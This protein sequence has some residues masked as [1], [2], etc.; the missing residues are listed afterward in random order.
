MGL[1]SSAY[2]AAHGVLADQ[3]LEYFN[4]EALPTATLAVKGRK[5]VNSRGQAVP[6]SDNVI[7]NGSRIAVAD[8]Q[9]MIIVEQGRILDVSTEPGEYIFDIGTEPSLL[10]GGTFTEGARAALEKT[11]ERFKFGGQPGKDTRVYYFN[12]KELLANPYGTANPVP[13]RVVDA[14]IG[15]D[16]D[17]AI[18][19]F[20]QYSYRI[21][22]PI[23]F[24][25]N[26][27]GNFPVAYTRDLIDGQLKAELLGALQPAVA[28]ISAAGVRYSALPGHTAEL[29]EALNAVLSPT[30]RETRGL[31]IVACG[32]SSVSA[33]PEDEQ[34]IKDLQ[35]TAV[36]R[37][38]TMAAATLI[39]AQASALEAAASNESGAMLGL[40]GLGMAHTAGGR[41][42]T[43]SLYALGRKSTPPHD[44][45][46]PGAEPPSAGWSCTS[47]GTTNE[48]R[49]C[50]ECGASK[51]PGVPQYRCDKCGWTPP[52]PGNPPKFCPDCGDP[53]DDGDLA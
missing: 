43:S 44:P 21:C 19:F 8:G 4:C 17:I 32:V 31:E 9:C 20:G 15:L 14:N 30:W 16:M 51:P 48:G 36:L 6:G 27:A 33:S 23:L 12:T 24:Y 29:A 2:A 47:C 10:G 46:P 25:M 39:G 35:R 28:R 22:D 18:R 3:W 26:V 13:F 45:T 7:S 50:H 37:D 5:W 34:M 53:F 49:F 40:M 42:D 38:P 52:D 11:W 41:L 1:I